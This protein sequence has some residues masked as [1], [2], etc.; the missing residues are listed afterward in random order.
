[1]PKPRTFRLYPHLR[2]F[3]LVTSLCFVVEIVTMVMLHDMTSLAPITLAV[4]DASVLST[5]LLISL[6]FW[7]LPGL[8]RNH[9]KAQ[10]Q[11]RLL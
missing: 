10:D 11:T 8:V 3:A 9:Q 1:M 4:L 6:Y 5:T 7:F 2:Y